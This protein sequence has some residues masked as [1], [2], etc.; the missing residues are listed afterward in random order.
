MDSHMLVR[1]KG[2]EDPTVS[3]WQS[4]HSLAGR[5]FHRLK[6]EFIKTALKGYKD[7]PRGLESFTDSRAATGSALAHVFREFNLINFHF[8]A[9]FV[10]WQLLRH[11]AIAQKP[12]VITLH[13][14]NA[15]TGGC[16]YTSGC[17]RFTDACGACPQLGS[18]VEHDFS[19]RNWERKRKALGARQAATCAV[20][21]S[22]WIAEEAKRSSLLRGYRVEAIH[23]GIDT[24]IFRPRDKGASRQALG[25]PLDARVIMFAASGLSNPRKGFAFLVEAIKGLRQEANVL[26]LAVGNGASSLNEDIKQ[27]NL[28]PVNNDRLLPL[29]YSAA[30]IFVIPSIEENFA[31]TAL[32]AAACGLPAIGFDV[33]GI[34]ELIVDAE[35]GFLVSAKS[36]ESLRDRIR[37]LVSEPAR[38]MEMGMRARKRVEEL[39]A[40]SIQGAKYRALYETLTS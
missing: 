36:V 11:P 10:D 35:T 9:G 18:K 12:I 17:N 38:A 40:L 13:D 27:L 30:D 2:S 6:E 1:S 15:F 39:F 16:H 31:L 24:A 37:A 14:T 29:V 22:Q 8:T 7:R 21:S 32:E 28:G 26:L 20:G 23:Y 25:V 3:E 33:G 4:N 5:V 34:P 19:R